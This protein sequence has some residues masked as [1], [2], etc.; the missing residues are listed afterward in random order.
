MNS[1][2]LEPA[3]YGI[4]GAP[5]G[6]TLGIRKDFCAWE[7]VQPLDAPEYMPSGSIKAG[8]ITKSGKQY[9]TATVALWPR[10]YRGVA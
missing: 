1:I 10:L 8:H 7:A 3:R 2:E 9:A 5:C 4:T 6:V